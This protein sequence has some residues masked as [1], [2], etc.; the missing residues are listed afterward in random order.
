MIEHVSLVVEH[1]PDCDITRISRWIFNCYVLHGQSGQIVVDAGLPRIADDVAGVLD[2]APGPL[3]AI[4]ATHGHTDHIAGAIELARRYR[5]PIF[6]PERTFDYLNG[7]RPRTPSTRQL[8]RTTP[9]YLGQRFDAAA[10]TAPLFGARIAGYGT[11]LGM[12]WSGPAPTGPLTPGQRLPGAPDWT[13]LATPGH[14]DDSIAFWHPPTGTLLSG[15]AVLTRRG[16]VWHAPDVIDSLAAQ[17]TT[18]QL[19]GLPVRWL[20]PGHGLPMR[21]EPVWSAAAGRASVRR[22]E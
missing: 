13:I 14:T 9:L 21:G 7:E 11:S 20:L 12:R 5:A 8:L 17:R 15:D 22:T 19:R 16:G 4:V 6:V 3:L 2:R 10:L 1:L 18:A